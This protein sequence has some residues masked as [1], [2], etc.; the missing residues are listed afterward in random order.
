MDG[1]RFDSLTR[2]ISSRRTLGGAIAGTLA[3]LLGLRDVA[4]APCPK[5]KKRCGTR[6]IPRRNCC[7]NANCRPG[8]TGRICRNGRCGCSAARP[9]NCGG[10]CVAA[11][12][13]CSAAECPTGATCSAGGVCVCPPGQ[14]SC[15][16][17]CAG[18]EGTSCSGFATC[19]SRSCDFLV[20]G[21]TC[22]SCSGLFCSSGADCCP[23]TP[24]IQNRC[25]GCLQRA[26]VCTP[27]GQPCCESDCSLQGGTNVCLSA[28]GGRCKHEANCASCYL[29][30][31]CLGICV[32][33]TCQR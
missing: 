12:G 26:V 14:Q 11:G 17:R 1:N 31:D 21:G 20:G 3:G 9:K 23:G 28:A 25:G 30:N 6:C 18:A 10:R 8:A 15:G 16:A 7:T 22:G 29:G 13:C 24:C 33:G 19:C 27:G 5:G 4:A 2:S 32:G